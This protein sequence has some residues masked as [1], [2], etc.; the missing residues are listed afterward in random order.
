MLGVAQLRQV[1]TS[2]KYM[3]LT[4]PIQEFFGIKI[5]LQRTHPRTVGTIPI[6]TPERFSVHLKILSSKKTLVL[7]KAV[8]AIMFIFTVK[9]QAFFHFHTLVPTAYLPMTSL[10]IVQCNEAGEQQG[11]YSSNISRVVVLQ[12]CF[13]FLSGGQPEDGHICSKYVADLRAKFIV[14]F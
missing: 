13:I 11:T 4:N 12:T 7:C 1:H 10:N 5:R 14:V 8:S 9:I 3:T 6:S 2:V